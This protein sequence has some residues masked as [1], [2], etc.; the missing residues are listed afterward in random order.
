MLAK[1]ILDAEVKMF[2][3][4]GVGKLEVAAILCQAALPLCPSAH[5]QT[6][7]S[8]LGCSVCLCNSHISHQDTDSNNYSHAGKK[9]KGV[10][11]CV[12]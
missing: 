9:G 5:S 3:A 11:V 8:V 4:V 12:V 1:F 10:C 2:M 6:G 7:M